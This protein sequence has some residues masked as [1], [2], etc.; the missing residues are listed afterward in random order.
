TLVIS[1]GLFRFKLLDIIPIAREKIIE[2][3][4]DGVLVLDAQDRAIDAN[5][6]MKKILSPYTPKIIGMS[7]A[8]LL[9]H[10]KTLHQIIAERVNNKTIIQLSDKTSSRFFEVNTT[11]LF[12]KH[13]VYSGLI[14]L[15]R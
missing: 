4:Q 15:F 8:H 10:E 14:L 2:A 5:T 12:D 13:K 6:E 3:M 1:Y 9:P 11:P 7:L